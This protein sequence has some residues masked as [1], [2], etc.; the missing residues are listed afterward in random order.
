MGKS[1]PA[2]IYFNDMF[3][4]ELFV[5]TGRLDVNK[6]SIRTG[7]ISNSWHRTAA[8]ILVLIL[9]ILYTAILPLELQ[10]AS[11]QS[12]FG[13][14]YVSYLS[15]TELPLLLCLLQVIAIS[16]RLD[17]Y[18]NVEESTRDIAL[19]FQK[20]FRYYT[21]ASIHFGLNEG[22]QQIADS[23]KVLLEEE[24]IGLV[25]I[26]TSRDEDI[27]PLVFEALKQCDAFMIFDSECYGDDA[28]NPCGTSKQIEYLRKSASLGGKMPVFTIGIESDQV[29]VDD[30]DVQGGRHRDATWLR[31]SPPPNGIMQQILFKFGLES[32]LDAEGQFVWDEDSESKGPADSTVNSTTEVIL[33]K[34]TDQEP[35]NGDGDS[36]KNA[37]EV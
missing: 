17:P 1:A 26:D 28:G 5:S 11:D 35:A 33:P 22:A 25:I 27:S 12:K 4:Y 23:L 18:R 19:Y 9:N 3:I 7:I 16:D 36:G 29:R 34:P 24:E 32:V 8:V 6:I 14:Q 21:F 20:G 15:R 10:N 2:S 30:N 37:A 31:N 13:P